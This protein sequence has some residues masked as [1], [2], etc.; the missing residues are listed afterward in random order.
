MLQMTKCISSPRTWYLFW[1]MLELKVLWKH[2]QILGFIS[3]AL[4]VLK[5]L[6]V[7]FIINRFD[8]WVYG[9]DICI[10]Q[11]KIAK[12]LPR[13]KIFCIGSYTKD[14][15][16][17][18]YPFLKKANVNNFL[19]WWDLEDLFLLIWKTVYLVFLA[20]VKISGQEYKLLKFE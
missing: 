6:L 8:M 12:L 7:T 16:T 10:S 18:V 1:F 15:M 2:Q 3:S 4:N 13:R 14:L 20:L 5:V 9:V 17:K 19:L 11:V